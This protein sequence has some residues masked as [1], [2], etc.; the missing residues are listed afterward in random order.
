MVFSVKKISNSNPSR[1]QN[2]KG[3]AEVRKTIRPNAYKNQVEVRSEKAQILLSF[4]VYKETPLLEFLYEKIKNESRNNIKRFLSNR[5]VLVNGVMTTQFDF[6]LVKEDVVQISRYAIKETQKVH[7]QLDILYE[8]DELIA[9]N[10]PSGL[11]SIESDQEKDNTAYSLLTEY[12]RRKDKKARI[13]IVH[14]IDKDTSGV[15]LVAKNEK[16]RNLLQHQWQKIVL[17]REY[18]AIC[19]GCFKEKEGT[20]Q[21]YLRENINHLMY[22][23]PGKDGQFSLTHYR[24]IK[25]NATYSMVDVTIDTGR[26]NQI[27]VHMGDI[28]HKVVGDQKYGPVS[29]PLKRLGLH[30]YKLEFMHP[31]RKEKMCF[32]AKIP[33]SFERLFKGK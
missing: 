31:L 3:K 14:R 32:T 19:E 26:K 29:D 13:Y 28:G 17:K 2:K 5:Q 23:A 33:A 9:I 4:H 20:I 25:E 7:I 15:L 30:A 6:L 18:I 21:S 16:I 11:L 22:S 1:V 24:V 27:R 12:V 8:D 10:K